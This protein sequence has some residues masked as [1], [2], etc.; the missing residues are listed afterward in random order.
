MPNAARVSSR[1]RHPLGPVAKPPETLRSGPIAPQI[2]DTLDPDNQVA[3]GVFRTF[4]I[5]KPD[6]K[7]I[8]AAFK[9]YETIRDGVEQASPPSISRVSQ[10]TDGHD[11]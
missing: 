8:L 11:P 1:Q 10:R 9:T 5:A 3:G 6:E 2:G 4:V 7:A